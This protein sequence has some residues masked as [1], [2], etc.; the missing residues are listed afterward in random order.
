VPKFPSRGCI[1]APPELGLTSLGPEEDSIEGL[2]WLKLV[3]QQSRLPFCDDDE[4]KVVQ[5]LEAQKQR[6][7]DKGRTHVVAYFV[8]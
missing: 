2:I 1:C 3:D 4:N 8:L 6:N 7:S 5:L